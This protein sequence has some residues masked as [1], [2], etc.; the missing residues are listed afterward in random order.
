[1]YTDDLFDVTIASINDGPT[2][3]PEV[4]SVI[5]GGTVT[6]LNDGI[7]T[8]VL[9]NDSDPENNQLQPN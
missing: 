6:T 7:T 8:S 9:D 5:N 4:I 2:T 1:M 3:N